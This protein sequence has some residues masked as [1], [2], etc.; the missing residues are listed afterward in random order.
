MSGLVRWLGGK[1]TC[2]QTLHTARVPSVEPTRRR[3][4]N[5]SFLQVVPGCHMGAWM[6]HGSHGTGHAHVHKHTH[7]RSVLKKSAKF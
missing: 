3:E 2:H 4:R 5:N 7:K 6:S 1:G